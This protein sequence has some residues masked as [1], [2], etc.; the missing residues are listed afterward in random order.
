M[1]H[2]IM[3]SSMPSRWQRHDNDND[4]HDNNHWLAKAI[5]RKYYISFR[6]L[7]FIN[8]CMAPNPN[9]NNELTAEPQCLLATP[10]TRMHCFAKWNSL[11]QIAFVEISPEHRHLSLNKFQFRNKY[12]VVMAPACG[13][14]A[15]CSLPQ[16]VRIRKPR[17]WQVSAFKHGPHEPRPIPCFNVHTNLHF[18]KKRQP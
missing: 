17:T 8:C 18:K 9:P 2:C 3:H 16:K 7:H 10:R 5:S 14:T 4:N 13:R 12:R 15:G 1:T 6:I 11:K